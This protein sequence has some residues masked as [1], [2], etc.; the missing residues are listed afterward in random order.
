MAD[1]LSISDIKTK[2]GLGS[3]LA[4]SAMGIAL[5][6]NPAGYIKAVVIGWALGGI[7]D[8]FGEFGLI[9]LDLWDLLGD[10]TFGL[11]AEVIPGDTLAQ[12]PLDL[13]ET[14]SEM[15]A[16]AVAGLGPAA[17]FMLMLL[18]AGTVLLVVGLIV[19]IIKLYKV[20]RIWLI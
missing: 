15:F 7:L 6:D 16:Q 8:L 20:V 18:W 5:T 19:G 1:G 3:I 11:L 2:L 14:L 13:L 17:P 4:A 9:V 12:I 10:I